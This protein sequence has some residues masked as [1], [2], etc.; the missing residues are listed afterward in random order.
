[1]RDIILMI[2]FSFF[3]VIEHLF[4]PVH[5]LLNIRKVM[6]DNGRMYLSTPRRPFWM[7]NRKNHFHEFQDNS[8]ENLLKRVGFEVVKKKKLR[9]RP[10]LQCFKGFRSFLRIFVDKSV[11]MECKKVGIPKVIPFIDYSMKSDGGTS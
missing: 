11:L 10:F 6:S 2:R 3:E 9:N 5:C 4:N 8:L 7:R 1:M